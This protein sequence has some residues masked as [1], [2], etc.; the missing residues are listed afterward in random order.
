M[1]GT[2]AFV[3]RASSS[4]A[5]SSHA[6]PQSAPS[7]EVAIASLEAADQVLAEL[8]Q[9]E[10]KQK[11]LT[12]EYKAAEIKLKKEF[13]PRH[14]ITRSGVEMT[15]ADR[16]KQL[17]QAL[18]EWANANRDR[19]LDDKKKS[20]DLNHGTLG[21][22]KTVRKLMPVAGGSESGNAGI[23][24]AIVGFLNKALES[25]SLFKAGCLRFVKVQVHFDREALFAAHQKNELSDEEL[26]TAGF[27]VT[28]GDADEFYFKQAKADVKSHATAE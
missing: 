11:E 8:G 10:A 18:T 28:G 5:A 12:A 13:E 27:D 6:A 14:K 17:R 3:P 24:E 23:L 25:Y 9:L 1:Q 21:W 26:K 16:M 7:V 22:K 15:I 19:V 20:R 4:P 2:F